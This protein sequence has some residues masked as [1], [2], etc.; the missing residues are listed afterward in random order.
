[1]E[2]LYKSSV[3]VKI[4]DQKPNTA[5]IK[6][7]KKIHPT[8]HLACI[9]ILSL[10]LTGLFTS[11]LAVFGIISHPLLSGQFGH[12]FLLN[13]GPIIFFVGNWLDNKD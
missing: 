4:R 13:L 10:S 1:M 8:I 12:W 9:L 5:F 11:F 6:N 3:F 7:S 2:N